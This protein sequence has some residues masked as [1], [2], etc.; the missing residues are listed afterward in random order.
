MVFK[1][2]IDDEKTKMRAMKAVV[3]T[4]GTNNHYLY[5]IYRKNI[6]HWFTRVLMFHTPLLM[7]QVLCFSGL[8]WSQQGGKGN[9]YGRN[10]SCVSCK[11]IKE[12]GLKRRLLS[13]G[14]TKEE[15]EEEENIPIVYHVNPSSSIY[16]YPSYGR[17]EYPITH[18]IWTVI[19]MSPYIQ[20][21]PLSIFL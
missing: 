16:G 12:I 1:S 19:A 9:C 4:G 17:D 21:G 2:T 13:I 14:P 5:C 15:K 11:K 7:L 10:R 20:E 18:L 6:F 8:Y 3:G